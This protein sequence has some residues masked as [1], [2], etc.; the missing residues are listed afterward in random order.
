[1]GER[2]VVNGK[3]IRIIRR[4]GLMYFVGSDGY[5]YSSPMQHRGRVKGVKQTKT[6]VMRTELIRD[7]QRYVYFI[8]SDG[9]LSRA[10][11]GVRR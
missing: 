5:I 1:M 11:R 9:Y 10:K 4:I 8:D 6:L 2:V 7:N 3:Y